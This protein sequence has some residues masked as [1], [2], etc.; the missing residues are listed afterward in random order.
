MED[1]GAR[2]WAADDFCRAKVKECDGFV[3]IVGHVFGSAPDGSN[4]SYT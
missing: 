1:F 3:G 4:R 2:D